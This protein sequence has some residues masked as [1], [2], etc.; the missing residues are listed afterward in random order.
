MLTVLCYLILPLQLPNFGLSR[1]WCFLLHLHI[2]TFKNYSIYR[3]AIFTQLYGLFSLVVLTFPQTPSPLHLLFQHFSSTLPHSCARLQLE[4]VIAP[5]PPQTLTRYHR[6]F[7]NVAPLFLALPQ[8]NTNREILSPPLFFTISHYFTDFA[9]SSSLLFFELSQ[10]F[11]NCA[12]PPPILILKLAHGSYNYS[13]TSPELLVTLAQNFYDCF[14]SSHPLLIV[15]SHFSSKGVASSKRQKIKLYI[16]ALQARPAPATFIAGNVV[17]SFQYTATNCCIKISVKRVNKDLNIKQDPLA[18]KR[19]VLSTS[20][21]S[22]T[23]NN[24]LP[25]KFKQSHWIGTENLRRQ[26]LSGRFYLQPRRIT[27]EFLE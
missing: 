25:L 24:V 10:N 15:M 26:I 22:V 23:E 20:S 7:R 17:N 18:I 8:Y 21:P 12:I 2:S 14:I 27:H 4:H 19:C 6:M 5:T 13:I 1:Q 3:A 16:S 9:T 11:P